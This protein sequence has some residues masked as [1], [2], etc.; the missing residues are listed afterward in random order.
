MDF[1]AVL[2]MFYRH[3]KPATCYNFHAVMNWLGSDFSPDINWNMKSDMYSRMA[4]TKYH[5]KRTFL[6]LSYTTRYMHDTKKNSSIAFEFILNNFSTFA[7]SDFVFFQSFAFILASL[8]L[9]LTCSLND[10]DQRPYCVRMKHGRVNGMHSLLLIVAWKKKTKRFS[11][12]KL[13]KK[14]RNLL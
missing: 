5:R 13:R 11:I 4:W 10:F 3:S 6:G 8:L 14:W 2:R 9:C 12:T 7:W 1:G